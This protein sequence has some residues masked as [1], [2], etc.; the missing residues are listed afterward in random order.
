MQNRS[1][2]PKLE[3]SSA[4]PPAK[5]N[6]IHFAPP[7]LVTTGTAERK[8]E[9]IRLLLDQGRAHEAQQVIARLLKPTKT[10][11][12]S[13]SVCAQARCALSLSW[14]MQGRYRES[15]EAVLMYEATTA[16]ADLD[17]SALACVRVHLGLA[18]NYTGDHP[19]A[20][21]ILNVA[22][23]AALENE[24]DPQIGA[25][26]VALARVYRSIN[27]YTI[28]RDY[29]TKA[30]AHFRQAGDWR[31][32][33]EAYFGLA[34]ANVFEGQWE[35][36]LEHLEQARALIGERP[37]TYLL[38]KIHTNMAGA[39]WF[40]KR[41]QEGIGYLEK[42][43]DYYEH[44]EHK[45]NAMDGYNNLGETLILV[46]EWERAQKAL[47]RALELAHEIDKRPAAAATV[48]DSLGK[49]Q[50]LRGALD[51]A[52][53]LLE[54]AV[55]TAAQH[56]NKWYEGQAIRTLSH[57]LLAK[58]QI[59]AAL[60]HAQQALLLGE[61]I[62]D[63]QAICEARLLRAE[64]LLG[65][66]Q[67]AE[68][69]AELQ[70]VAEETRDSPNDLALAGNML[71]VQGMLALANNDHSQAVQSFGR[72][73]SIFEMLGDVYRSARAHYW[74]GCA[75][76]KSQPERAQQ[77]LT[78]ASTSLQKLGARLALAE[79]QAALG[80][81][82]QAPLVR[83]DE[84]VSLFQLLT[85]RL[86]EATASRE[87]LLRELAAVL[88]EETAA[89]RI[90]I[91]EPAP[92]SLSPTR[93]KIMLAHGW[94]EAEG[95]RLSAA[96]DQLSDEY[97]P[98]QFALD[99]DLTLI[100]LQPARAL[101]A[102]V[103]I[104]PRGADQLPYGLSLRSLLRV[105]ELGLSACAWH[106]K[107]AEAT[108]PQAQASQAAANLMPGFIHSS[109]Q[110]LRL[111]DEIHK[112]RSSD[113]T[114]LVTGE[115]G[116]G[117]ELVARAIHALS[118]RRAKVFVPFNCTAVPKELSD[119]FLFGYKR[120]AF[121]GAIADSAG[122]IRA[123]TGGTL[124]LD[125]VGDLPLEIQPKLLRFLQEGEIQPLGEQRPIKVDVRV[126]AATNSDLE[127]MVAAG[128]FRE[129]L[130]YRLNVIRL[131]VPPLRERRSEIPAIVNY[132][133]KHYAEKFGRREI[134]ISPPALDLLTVYDWPGNVRQVTNEIQ[135]LVARLEDGTMIAPE[136]LSPEL[137]RQNVFAPS[138]LTS[139]MRN[140]F[141]SQSDDNLTL[142]EA[143][144]QFKQALLYERLR[145]N[146]GN[147][148]RTARELGMTR[149]GLQRMIVR[150]GLSLE[151]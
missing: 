137:R 63:R 113:V 125:E 110:M 120:G 122:V 44:T 93:Q 4:Q 60:E 134:Q 143:V 107:D 11:R 51:E 144:D 97:S 83:P 14:E 139:E 67:Q 86:S 129:D 42:A 103:L 119:A 41:P 6:V 37:A 109:P 140:H 89:Q 136:H 131:Q 47:A 90:L 7:R 18:Y 20:V 26:Y 138:S 115:S 31:G 17:Q 43:V 10:N 94:S 34:L 92:H 21:A 126:I 45:A 112:I 104:A 149:R 121:T 146:N 91:L 12:I 114:A 141:P 8:L 87:L 111:V 133:I 101:P 75:Y 105:V 88:R 80:A 30:L 81:L 73:L 95:T 70:A 99:H 46:G 78:Q 69:A 32:L 150:Y 117:K 64:A 13:S 76:A 98:E 118:S 52:Q 145:K 74:Q 85:L 135:R 3:R 23:R 100:H 61:K 108:N 124:F 72:S 36:G 55:A 29:A 33:A 66:G 84:V 40:L 82:Q 53:K 48:L 71:R 68:C 19:K 50:L 54:E 79:A 59:P 123:A 39:C 58:G 148:S 9:D 128:Q 56:G 127:E 16:R 77:H 132:Y 116:T 102:T 22:L 2:K 142:I 65:A 130:Y 38:G 5:L 24:S 147:V 27:E 62:G 35:A 25:V 1:P 57:C 15:L 151:R 49:L 96:Y 28:A 106:E